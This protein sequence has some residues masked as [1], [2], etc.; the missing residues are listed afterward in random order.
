MG[1]P[2]FKTWLGGLPVG[3]GEL[4]SREPIADDSEGTPEVGRGIGSKASA[5]FELGKMQGVLCIT[6]GV[7]VRRE[8]LKQRR[9]E[10]VLHFSQS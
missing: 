3:A 10:L 4:D 5:H 1:H 7:Q 2:S 9:S 8:A 6:L